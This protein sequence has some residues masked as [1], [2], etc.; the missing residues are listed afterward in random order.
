MSFKLN[1][2]LVPASGDSITLL[3]EILRIGRRGLCDICM[4]FANVSGL[5][6]ELCFCEGFWKIRDL[7]STNGIKVNGIRVYQKVLHPGDEISIGKRRFTIQYELPAKF[8]P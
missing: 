3:R 8:D 6:A 5:H 1:G 7:N 2:E 4:D